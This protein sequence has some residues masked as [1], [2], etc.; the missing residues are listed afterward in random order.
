[1]Y[2][3][4]LDTSFNILRGGIGLRVTGT[5]SDAGDRHRY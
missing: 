2:L 5:G 1:M 3:Y 4:E